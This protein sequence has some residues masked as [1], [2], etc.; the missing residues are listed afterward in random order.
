M[1]KVIS[2]GGTKGGSGKTT[3]SVYVVT[4]IYHLF[5]DS[6][7][8]KPKL[9]IAIIDFDPQAS[10]Y[11]TRKGEVKPERLKT[12]AEELAQYYP[13]DYKERLQNLFEVKHMGYHQ[14][15]ES[16]NRG[17]YDSYDLLVLDFP[18]SDLSD[19][20]SVNIAA[21]LD[22]IDKVAIPVIAKKKPIG[23]SIKLFR[24]LHKKGIKHGYFIN[25]AQNSSMLN[26]VKD[27]SKNGAH[28]Q[29]FIKQSP[30]LEKIKNKKGELMVVTNRHV[31][32]D[33]NDS[34]ILFF[35]DK[36]NNVKS[37]V[38]YLLKDN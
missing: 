37:L 2:I 8:K 26:W 36:E 9:K 23:S 33:E 1:L 17:D 24:K 38:S 7:A 15:V 14:Y 21:T 6:K 3:W 16:Y 12:I 13:D 20:E 35:D 11:D 4:Y 19:N 30:S 22:T 32:Y 31:L 10:L 5:F 25:F 28:E 27:E 29:I 18:G 34:T